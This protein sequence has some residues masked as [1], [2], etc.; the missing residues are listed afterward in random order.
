MRS[1]WLRMTTF[2]VA[3]LLIPCAAGASGQLTRDVMYCSGTGAG[4]DNDKSRH[5][6]RVESFTTTPRAV[7]LGPSGRRLT[8]IAVDPCSSRAYAIAE[9]EFYSVDLVKGGVTLIGTEGG[10][11]GERHPDL[12]SQNALEAG[13]DGALYVW[14][15]RN[16]IIYRVD[17]VAR[18]ISAVVDTKHESG[19]GLA[20]EPGGKWLFGTTRENLLIKVNLATKAVKVVGRLGVTGM[21]GLDFTV[22]G[23]LYG[24]R[25]RDGE[26]FAEVYRIST[27]TGRA[28]LVGRIAG[29][30][31]LG[32]GGM[33]I[34]W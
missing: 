23:Q 6:Y 26:G 25:G 15:W 30:Q 8:D 34:S 9:G 20:L 2:S 10:L 4:E 21:P 33:T 27:S 28:T 1:H 5:I 14:G 12:S 22:Q 31:Q 3:C 29:A 7:D 11:F 18:T 24:T 16:S 13:C 17:P 32:N 19:G